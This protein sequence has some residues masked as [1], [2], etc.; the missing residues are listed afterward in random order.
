MHR[1]AP[2][3]KTLRESLS[4]LAPR[5]RD[6]PR[7]V[8]WTKGPHSHSYVEDAYLARYLGYTLAEGDDLAVRENR[9]MLKTLGGLLPVEVLLRRLD[10]D[11]CDPVELAN[12]SASGVSGLVEVLRCGQVAIANSLGSRLVE[13]PILL[14]F[15]AD[16]CRKRLG[17]EL[18]IPT[19]PTWWCGQGESLEY[20]LRHLDELLIR[21]AFRTFD[22]PATRPSTLSAAARQQLIEQL[23]AKPWVM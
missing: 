3:F 1:L 14:P 13:S 7:I 22:S 15:I 12:N 16:I 20:V 11:D 2:F 9:V 8:L 6:N 18:L 17:Q 4:D 19:V 23:R 21:P 5:S 10:D